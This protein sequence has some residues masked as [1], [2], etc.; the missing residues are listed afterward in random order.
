MAAGRLVELAV[1]VAGAAG[2]RT[3]TYHVPERLADLVGGEAV[4]VEF[5]RRQVLAIVV[6]EVEASPANVATKPVL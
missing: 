5:G 6:G 4:M 1:D 2:G 3:Y